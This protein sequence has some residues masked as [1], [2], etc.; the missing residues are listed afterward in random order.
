MHFSGTPFVNL[1]FLDG[2][3]L[4]VQITEN[5]R[6]NWLYGSLEPI[7]F[8]AS[9]KAQVNKKIIFFKIVIKLIFFASVSRK[10]LFLPFTKLFLNGNLQ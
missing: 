2:E 5:Y 8:I 3:N 9:A 4:R 1:P 7:Y 10:I 6:Y